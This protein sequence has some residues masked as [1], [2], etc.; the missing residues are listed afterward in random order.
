MEKKLQKTISY[1]L[2]FIDS[3]RVMVSL[4]SNLVYNFSEAIHRTKCKFEDDDKKSEICRIEY[5]Y[6][7]C[8]LEYTNLMI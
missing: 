6:C 2:Q 1:T 3:T 7:H 4:S 5:K 8:F